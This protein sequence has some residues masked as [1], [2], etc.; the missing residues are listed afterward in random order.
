MHEHR[1]LPGVPSAAEVAEEG[2][3]DLVEL[4]RVLLEKVE[5]MSLY[6]IQLE[7]SA[8]EHAAQFKLMDDRLR[9]L[10]EASAQ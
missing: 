1:H 9:R 8:A 10:E 2:R 3:V 4:N 6:I 7:R 5:E